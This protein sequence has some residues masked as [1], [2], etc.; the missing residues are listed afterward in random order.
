MAEVGTRVSRHSA[1]GKDTSQEARRAESGAEAPRFKRKS[2]W[3]RF[4]VPSYLDKV[5]LEG[6]QGRTHNIPR[7][8]SDTLTERV[9]PGEKA[10]LFHGALH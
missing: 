5:L 6:A 9:R 10:S 8:L 3:S 1:E 7:R 2:Y 4:T